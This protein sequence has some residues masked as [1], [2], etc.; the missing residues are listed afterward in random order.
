M[1]LNSSGPLSFGGSTVGQS[2]NLELGVSATALASINSTAFRTLAGVPSGQ[3]SINNF[4]GKSNASYFVAYYG[5]YVGDA[6]GACTDSSGT[7]CA[8]NEQSG[9]NVNLLQ[10]GSTGSFIRW[11][12]YG[13]GQRGSGPFTVGTTLYY[14]F[15]NAAVTPGQVGA[16]SINT[17][18]GAVIA[19]G[20]TAKSGGTSTVTQYGNV[21][22]DSS[23]NMFTG[24]Y[25][26]VGG[27]NYSVLAA[28]NSSGVYQGDTRPSGIGV[29]A[30][31]P[32]IAVDSSNN[33]YCIQVGSTGGECYI[34]KMSYSGGTF[35]KTWAMYFGGSGSFNVDR[36]SRWITVVGSYVYV[37]ITPGGSPI[38]TYVYKL[39]ASNGS[40]VWGRYLNSA[41][42]QNKATGIS[43]DS[44]DNVYIFGYARTVYPETYFRP[45]VVKLNSAG[46]TQ[47]RREIYSNVTT[48]SWYTGGSSADN[49]GNMSMSMTD[50]NVS[51]FMKFPTDGSKTG[52]YSVGGTTLTYAATTGVGV[53]D[54]NTGIVSTGTGGTSYGLSSASTSASAASLGITPTITIA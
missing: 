49:N 32:G 54:Y 48:A 6:M 2:I 34:V 51:Y 20:A 39:N 13:G 4:Y 16:T 53:S 41:N 35:T 38:A 15:R 11:N 8:I 24:G 9:T 44:S 36:W 40:L 33:V 45:Y 28:Y 10:I 30:F 42:N 17:S 26:N 52:T 23:G 5:S 37:C 31:I 46:T 12:Y 22:A 14:G 50:F 29:A 18:T 21:A 19:T 3:I 1:A 47:F 25:Y 27:V 43:V 7:Y